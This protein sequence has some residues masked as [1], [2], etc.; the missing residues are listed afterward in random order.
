MTQAVAVR[1]DGDTFQARSFWSWASRLLD[2]DSPI[3]KV[4]FEIGPKAFDD[5]WVEYAPGRGPRDHYGGTIRREHVQCKWHSMPDSYGY[6]QL[7]DPEF[8][9]ANARSLLQRAREAQLGHAADGIGV[10]FVLRTNWR[11]DRSDPLREMIGTRSNAMRV[12]RLFGSATDDSRAGMVRK[13]WREHLD[14]DDEALRVFART[15]GFGQA[16]D[17][18]DELRDRLDVD[19]GLVGL[20]RVPANESAFAYDDLVYRWM[21][22]GRLEHDR[23]SFRELCGDEGLLAPAKPQP[24]VFGVKS[25]EHAIDK[26]EDRCAQ[27]LD[28]VPS[29]DE[30]Y[31]RSEG[32]W[33]AILY[34][35]LRSYLVGV[36]AGRLRLR[37]A[38]DAHASLAFAAGSILNV[39]SGR[40]VEL[41]QRTN[42]REIWSNDDL[43]PDPGWPGW[44]FDLDPVPG[45]GSDLAVAVGLTHDVAQAVDSYVRRALPTVGRVLACRPT[46]G[47]GARSVLCGRHA[48]DLAEALTARIRSERSPGD[49][50]VHL[51]VAAPNAFTFLLG[52]RQIAIGRT[53]L[54]EFDFDDAR[55]G[56]YV[57]SFFL[58]LGQRAV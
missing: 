11:L 2:A 34:P 32:E 35:T 27:V 26:L 24:Q 53:C 37:L 3:V 15:L 54:Y 12:E 1:R 58:P 6:A 19:F 20:R 30:R 36:A 14:I 21:A 40:I 16:T 8:I 33:A 22:Q 17:S 43:A 39:K 10:R 56:T 42:G 46:T 25:F 50:P 28:L 4:G 47:S 55:G 57:P 31:I 48:S 18:L 51:F 9:N 13:A 5:I 23:G 49:G 41:E 52:Q 44:T 29:F 7:I 38:L 45:G